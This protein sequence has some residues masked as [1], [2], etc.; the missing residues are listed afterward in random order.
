MAFSWIT[1]V[2][3]IP[4]GRRAHST[5]L[6][7]TGYVYSIVQ[8]PYTR[9]ST[10]S[11]SVPQLFLFERW[12]PADPHMGTGCFNRRQPVSCSLPQQLS[13]PPPSLEGELRKAPSQPS[14]SR[15]YLRYQWEWNGLRICF[16]LR[17]GGNLWK[18]VRLRFYPRLSRQTYGAGSP[19]LKCARCVL[20]Y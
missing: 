1:F 2:L 19:S 20:R 10:F 17:L 5:S 6:L 4:H 13:Q 12:T 16:L 9:F 7:L 15:Q 8:T 11:D 14:S 3:R 18:V